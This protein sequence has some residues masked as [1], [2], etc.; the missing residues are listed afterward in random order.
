M[1]QWVAIGGT[2]R[3]WAR[4]TWMLGGANVFMGAVAAAVLLARGG[5]ARDAAMVF[6]VIV[7]FLVG[8]IALELVDARTTGILALPLLGIIAVLLAHGFGAPAAIVAA[9]A[10]ASYAV[11]GWILRHAVA[12]TAVF[13]HGLPGHRIGRLSTIAGPPVHCCE[14][15][16]CVVVGWC[17]TLCESARPT[18]PRRQSLRVG[19]WV[20]VGGRKTGPGGMRSVGI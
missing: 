4:E 12:R 15:G 1:R 13:N 8:F 2:R 18:T 6:A 20:C 10:L 17:V 9:G 7:L 11:L 19:G 5:S 3:R 16:V 14:L